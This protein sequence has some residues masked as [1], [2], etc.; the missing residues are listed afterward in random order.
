MLESLSRRD[1]LVRVV[2][3]ELGQQLVAPSGQ[4]GRQ[5]LPHVDWRLPPGEHGLVVGQARHSWPALLCG[6]A[7]DTEYPGT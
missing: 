6:G 4:L 7:Q 1:P 3:E 5:Q 2:G